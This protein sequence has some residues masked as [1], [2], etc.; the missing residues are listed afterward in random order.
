[1]TLR[2]WAVMEGKIAV[3]AVSRA[4]SHT[5]GSAKAFSDAPEEKHTRSNQTASQNVK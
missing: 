3:Q 2:A 1:M 4:V 5:T